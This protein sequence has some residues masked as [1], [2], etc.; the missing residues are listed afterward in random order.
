M[1]ENYKNNEA[2]HESIARLHTEQRNMDSIGIDQQSTEV[3]LRWI[4]REDKKVAYCVEDA[5]PQI[6]KAVDLLYER[7]KEG[8]RIVYVGAGTSARFGFLDA[9]ECPPTYFVS[10]EKVICLMAGGRECM[11]RASENRE[12]NACDAERD[13]IEANLSSVDTVV[14]VAASGRTPYCIGALKYAEKIGAG[15]IS[16]SCNPQAEL[17]KYAEVGIEVDTGAEVIMGSTR[18]KAGAAQKFVLNMMSTAV[19]IKLGRTYDNLLLDYT[20]KN[21][22]EVNRIVREFIEVT[23]N[24]DV[25]H[26]KEQL[27]KAHSNMRAAFFMEKFGVTYEQAMEADERADRNVKKAIEIIQKEYMEE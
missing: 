4:N 11:F 23:G 18:M 12:D 19:M 2:F 27:E 26:A 21:T 8:G 24:P 15:R 20:P 3:M 14:A 1:Y 13:L 17:T 22:K 5:I 7:M 10:H 6:T 16:V 9:A 25:E